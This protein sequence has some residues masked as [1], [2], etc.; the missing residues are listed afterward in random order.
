LVGAVTVVGC[1]QT[2]PQVYSQPFLKAT[3]FSLGYN[4][5]APFAGRPA[6][7]RIL[8]P[9]S[10]S[11]PVET[12]EENPL[13]VV[14]RRVDGQVPIILYWILE[15]E[16]PG[17]AVTGDSTLSVF[18]EGQLASTESIYTFPLAKLAQNDSEI[19]NAQSAFGK[20]RNYLLRAVWENNL[21]QT[22]LTTTTRLTFL[23]ADGTP[24]RVLNPRDPKDAQVFLTGQKLQLEDNNRLEDG[25][26]D[27][28]NPVY[29][30]AVT[31]TILN[32]A[33]NNVRDTPTLSFELTSVTPPVAGDE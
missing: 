8:T 18:P 10:G 14:V 32:A 29:P 11:G 25:Q 22:N 20:K 21:N 17:A 5:G 1:A 27:T 6:A 19:A 13:Q 23:R 24:S 9:A 31:S 26:L 30:S 7:V 4:E 2:F 3:T 28:E 15:I 16:G 12:F 33:L